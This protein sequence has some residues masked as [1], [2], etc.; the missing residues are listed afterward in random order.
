MT[1]RVLVT[2]G[3]GYLGSV[4]VPN[5]LDE[6]Y[7]VTVFDR[8][9]FGKE[10][11]APVADHPRLKLI[12]GDTTQLGKHNG[13][14]EGMDAV[15]HLAAFS[16]DPSCDLKPEL[17]QR[18]NFDA[19]TE[20]A[21]RAARA[22]VRRFIFASSCS[23]Y[24]SNPSPTVDEQSE[25]HPVSLY[26]QK[27]VEAEQALFALPAP[28]M[29]ITALRMATLYGLSP[30][31]RF[32]LAI[33]LMVMNAV[34]RRSIFV[35]GGGSQWRPFV[36]VAD[37]ASAYITTLEAPAET[38]DRETFNVGS[39]ANNFQIQDLAWTVRDALPHLEVSVTT[40]PDDADKR[41]YRVGFQ[42]IADKLGFVTRCDLKDSIVEIAREIQSGRLGD[43][44]DTRF[45]TVK[46][47]KELSESPAMAGG[48]AARADYLPFALPLIGREEEEEVLD[49]MRSGWMTTGPKTKRFE[50]MLADYAGAK[51]A[52]AVNS[53][54]AALHIA[55]AA[56]GIK[57]GDEV[58]T[59]GITF[60]ATANVVI[61]QGAKPVLVD[62]DPT[63]LNI[64]PEA[65]ERAITPR[66]RAIIP[67]HMAGQPCDM[68][69]IY[70]IARRH[71]L[72]VIEDAAHGI[73]AEYRGTRIGN[74]D[75]SLA[76][77]YSFYPIKNM[78][79][80]EGGAVLTNDDDFAD[81]ARLYS[82]HGISKDAWKRYSNAGYQHWDT[83]LPGFKYNMT[84]IGSALG[85]HQLPRL[86]GFLQT[87][88]RYA[89]MYQ[90]AFADLPEIE[91]LRRVDDV[92]HA[93]HLFVILLRLDRLS[94]NR[95]G[96]MEA[97][98]LENI[99][100]GVH[101]RS[102]HIQPF[103]AKKYRLRREDLPHAAA[104]SDRLLSLPL[105]PKMT[106]GDVLDVIEAVRKVVSAYRISTNGHAPAPSQLDLR[107]AGA[108]A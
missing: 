11:L 20:L 94:I 31:M 93:W 24:G 44:S 45:Y 86:N 95:D 96:F 56:A 99:G 25:L 100:T 55:V 67:V 69:A 77:C 105:Y 48:E 13:F 34:T 103:Y 38:I 89:N 52:I 78:T 6:G 10:P 46:R 19:T 22:G 87:R 106:E 35:L 107:K 42:K 23:V 30:R 53:C 104:V 15:I 102:L 3:A 101:F 97:L 36:H 5:L 66:T 75:G 91:M 73:G 76:S 16:N 70:D 85:I 88:E 54:T 12:E 81:L 59:S 80:I 14:L 33:N 40:V 47:M 49:C 72:A 63:T 26:A 18:V 74:L 98:R 17:T 60:P 7:E 29:T 2:G 58:I 71:K 51:H 41:S 83:M 21:R 37:A 92:R 62:V 57:R 4:L 28:G 43:C 90:D 9:L 32:D 39:N 108:A 64:N 82:L 79:T 65:I 1:K 27:K 50:Q 61:H 84:D 8:F 68:D